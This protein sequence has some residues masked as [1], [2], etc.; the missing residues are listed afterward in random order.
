MSSGRKGS[1]LSLTHK[2]V[3]IV[4]SII[5]ASIALLTW[6][7]IRPDSAPIYT[8]GVDSSAVDTTNFASKHGSTSPPI[9]SVS[10]PVE[11]V[12][13]DTV[14]VL[15]PS[16]YRGASIQ[17]D[18]IPAQVLERTQTAVKLRITV[19]QTNQT[20]EIT[21]ADEPG[22]VQELPLNFDQVI[23]PCQN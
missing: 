14:N 18:G 13:Y 4:A 21:K 15:L 19:K 23:T 2:V 1:K 6:L 8:G 17:I 7:N 20:I 16:R 22:C 9:G 5:I 3:T 12:R 11:S 10:R